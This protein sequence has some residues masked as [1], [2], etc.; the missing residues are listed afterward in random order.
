MSVV[1]NILILP[2]YTPDDVAVALREGF[3]DRGG[4]TV[5][6]A[7]L[8]EYA[9]GVHD[10]ADH[11]SGGKVPECEVWACAANHCDITEIIDW[12]KT[13]P[14]TDPVDIVWKSEQVHWRHESLAVRV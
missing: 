9:S 13:L 12:L 14:W 10:A 8:A 2:E 6:F 4:R 11:W 1:T 7:D 3:R 5:N